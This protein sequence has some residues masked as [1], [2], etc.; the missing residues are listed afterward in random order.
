MGHW[1]LVNA[2]IAITCL[3]QRKPYV[4]CPAGSLKSFGRSTR[5]KK[6][7]DC[8]IGKYIIRKA[9]ACIAITED[10]K[11]DFS[12]YGIDP[13]TIIVIPNGIDPDQYALTDNANEY[14]NDLYKL[15]S[16]TDY[17]LYLGRM[18]KIKGPDLLL[19]AFVCIADQ[20]PDLHLVLAGPDSGL[21]Q[22]LQDEVI[23]HGYKSRVHFTGYLGGNNKTYAIHKARCLIIPS[24]EEAMSMV[25]LEAGICGTPV[26]FTDRCGLEEFNQAG[27]GIM[28]EPET[29]SIINGLKYAISNY[30]AVLEKGKRLKSIIVEKYLWDVQADRYLALYRE[31]LDL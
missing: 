11:K 6:I 2:L 4:I 21:L 17:I 30:D 20:N 27:A 15:L 24:R 12:I 31:I 22:K 7:Y 19:D 14:S 18:N 28:V 5:L 8:I 3:L 25:V 26:I 1:T 13:G 10:E 23:K 29:K 9:S 16:N